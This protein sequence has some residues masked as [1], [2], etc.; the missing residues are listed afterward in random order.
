ME[1]KHEDV[2]AFVDLAALNEPGSYTINASVFFNAPPGIT[3]KEV[4]PQKVHL[5]LT[6]R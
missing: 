2:K 4:Y 3:L 6:H 5:K 1:I